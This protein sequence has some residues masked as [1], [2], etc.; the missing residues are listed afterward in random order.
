MK[1]LP[2]EL[3]QK[4]NKKGWKQDVDDQKQSEKNPMEGDSKKRRK[5]S[6]QE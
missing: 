6:N 2:E 4:Y 3:K 1:Q 5:Y